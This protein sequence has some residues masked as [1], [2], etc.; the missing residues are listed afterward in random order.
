MAITKRG[1]SWQASAKFNGKRMRLSFRTEQEARIWVA[2]AKL[3]LEKK[4]GPPARPTDLGPSGPGKDLGE[5]FRITH[6]TKWSSCWSTSM[7]ELGTLVV[8]EL[9]EGT[10]VDAVNFAM[11]ASWIGDLRG[12]GLSQSTIN[13]RLACLSSMLGTALHMGWIKEKPKLPF[14]KE[15]KRERRYLTREEE[16]AILRNL[17]GTKEWSI[18]VVAADTGLRISEIL[19]LRW[20]NVRPDAVT[21]EK[22]KNGRARTVPLTSRVKEVF[23][24]IPRDRE[25]PFLGVSPSET[26][27]KFKKAAMIAGISDK[28]VV[29]HS[30]RHTCASRLVMAG[31]DV[32]RV[33][34]WMGHKSVTTT[35]I[36]AHLA[37]SSLSDAVARL[38]NSSGHKI[39]C[40][41]RD[42]VCGKIG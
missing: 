2:E 6:Q 41:T 29:F 8:R 3:A 36:Y 9:G 21:V 26:S 27:R 32:M 19:S 39:R 15:E 33:K 20:R 35:M 7:T 10:R 4:L 17:S 5:L 30:L 28:S 1:G 12:K 31:V 16:E 22:T 37:P 40:E 14:G 18:V 23:A 11:V 42:T 38:E 13:R 24:A 34:E 25:G